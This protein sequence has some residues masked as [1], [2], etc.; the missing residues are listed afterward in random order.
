MT[1]Q[2][3]WKSSSIAGSVKEFFK[4]LESDKKSK[5]IIIGVLGLF[6]LKA[7]ML[8]SISIE[9]YSPLLFD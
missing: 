7:S 9:R 8:F 3:F 5:N 1:S 4:Y 6:S 2:H